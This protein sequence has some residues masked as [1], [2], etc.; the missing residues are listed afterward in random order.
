MMENICRRTAMMNIR[1]MTDEWK[2]LDEDYLSLEAVLDELTENKFLKS[3]LAGH[4]LCY[5]VKPQETSFANHSRISLP[6]YDSLVRIKGGGEAII[7]VFRKEL[8]KVDVTILTERFINGFADIQGKKVGRFVLNSGEEITCED[9]IFTIHPKEILKV[10]PR[11]HLSNA[12]I[13]RIEAFEPSA[14]FFSLQGVLGAGNYSADGEG[15]VVS[16]LPM[17]DLNKLFDSRSAGH[18]AMVMQKNAENV[19]GI[20]CPKINALSLSSG[21]EISQ[22]RNTKSGSRPAEY[23]EYKQRCAGQMK[24]RIIKEFPEYSGSLKIIDTASMLT[25]RDYLNSY[26]GAA[27]GIKQKIGQ[28]N[29]FGRLP[30]RNIYAVGQSS[31]LPGV[32]GAMLSSFVLSS[33]ILGKEKF[34]QFRERQLCH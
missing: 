13:D 28:I 17:A 10:L 34:H 5:G 29:L 19:E 33:V 27:Y 15:D 2:T 21:E 12:F 14:G 23:Y 24:D 25:F 22:W 1:T 7:Q 30:L 6:L 18:S 26:D 11:E 32:I 31:I 8:A 9:C 16:F 4:C 20:V 3:L